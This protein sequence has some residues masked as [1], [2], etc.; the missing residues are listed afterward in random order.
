MEFIRPD[1]HLLLHRKHISVPTNLEMLQAQ[2]PDSTVR[3]INKILKNIF[4]CVFLLK[5]IRRQKGTIFIIMGT[6]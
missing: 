4:V 1:I 3:P 6:M 5:N 2:N